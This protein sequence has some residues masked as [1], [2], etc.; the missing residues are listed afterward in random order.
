MLLP[1]PSWVCHMIVSTA[2]RALSTGLYIVPRA[3]SSN[4]K[5]S[6]GAVPELQLHPSVLIN[7]CA[8]LQP[9]GGSVFGQP[10]MV[11]MYTET[12]PGALRLP[13]QIKAVALSSLHTRNV[14]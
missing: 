14:V 4:G 8:A 11:S 2:P 3:Y 12:A 6:K 1:F 7:V 10:F 5:T 9:A 13:F